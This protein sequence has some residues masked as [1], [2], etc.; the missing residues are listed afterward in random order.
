ML[1]SDGSTTTEGFID[2]VGDTRRRGVELSLG[3]TAGPVDYS[4]H[5]TY[6]E[7]EFRDSFLVNSP[8]HPLRDPENPDKPAAEAL[9]VSAGN[10]LP[11]VPQNLLRL[12]TSWHVNDQVTL[13]DCIGLAISSTQNNYTVLYFP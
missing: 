3:G 4:A 7:A 13:G 11:G 1:I 10:Q 6:I 9:Q 12:N 2:N 8:N 5:Y